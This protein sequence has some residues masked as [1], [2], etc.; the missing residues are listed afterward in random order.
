M[1]FEVIRCILCHHHDIATFIG[2]EEIASIV[3]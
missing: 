1:C 3:R 2:L